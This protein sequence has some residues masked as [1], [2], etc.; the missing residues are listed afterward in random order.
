MKLAW[1]FPAIVLAIVAGSLLVAGCGDGEEEAPA[2]PS[3][4]ATAA[5][6]ASPAA[7]PSPSTDGGTRY[8]VTVRF[9]TT[10]TQDDIDEVGTLLGAYDDE[11]EYTVMESWPPVGRALLTTDVDDFCQTVEAELGAKSYIDDVSCGPA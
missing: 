11:V 7:S 3:A 10:V 2:T 4:T 6:V 5:A 9:N 8:E 1:R